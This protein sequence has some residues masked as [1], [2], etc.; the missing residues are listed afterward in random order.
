[1]ST[2]EPGDSEEGEGGIEGKLRVQVV[3]VGG[4]VG[5]HRVEGK[6]KDSH[7]KDAEARQG[8]SKSTADHFNDYICEI[9]DLFIGSMIS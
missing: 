1:M 8:Q 5:H 9:L 7:K 6:Q 3:E 2:S 4:Q